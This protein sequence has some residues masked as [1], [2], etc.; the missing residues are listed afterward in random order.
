[1]NTNRAAVGALGILNLFG[2]LRTWRALREVDRVRA[3]SFTVLLV[4]PM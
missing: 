4:Q 2:S 3:V 1:M